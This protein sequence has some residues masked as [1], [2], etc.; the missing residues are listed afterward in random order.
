MTS[1]RSFVIISY[2]FLQVALFSLPRYPILNTL[3]ATFLRIVGAKIGKRVIFYPGVWIAPGRNLEIGDDVDLALDVLIISSGEVKIGS[4]VLIGYRT[5]IIS[6]NHDIPP[7]PLRIFDS[8]AV[9][10]PISIADDVWIG[11]NCMIMPGVT[12][13]E[14]A[15]VAG[16]SVVTKNVEPYSIV[17]GS[18]ARLIRYRQ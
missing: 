14:G 1:L 17:G 13:G 2:E 10:G 18:P 8:K 12:I 16:G 6:A 5:Q 4:R 15:V 11:G 7:K 3:K 9:A